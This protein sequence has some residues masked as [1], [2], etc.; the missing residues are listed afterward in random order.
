MSRRNVI[1]Y[2]FGFQKCPKSESSRILE[3][4]TQKPLCFVCVFYERDIILTLL[5]LFI[6][7]ILFNFFIILFL[8][9]YLLFIKWLFWMIEYLSNFCC[10][11]KLISAYCEKSSGSP[12]YAPLLSYDWNLNLCCMYAFSAC[13]VLFHLKIEFDWCWW[14]LFLLLLLMLLLSLLL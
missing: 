9:V 10:C 7:L 4:W 14:L 11:F 5:L 8:L 13:F 2:W 6:I 1:P 12:W 3:Y